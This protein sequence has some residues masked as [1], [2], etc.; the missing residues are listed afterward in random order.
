[1]TTRR[2]HLKT[3]V[4]GAG[5]GLFCRGAQPVPVRA[6]TRGPKF[7][8]FG[9]YDKLEFDPTNRYILANEIDF[10]NRAPAAGDVLRLGMIDT[11]ENDRWIALGD[12]HAFS[13]QQGCM[14]Q[15][16]P[17]SRSEVIWN[18]REGDRYVARIADALSRKPVRTI[19][20]PVHSINADA[21]VALHED[22][23][24]LEHLRPGYGYA[25][26]PDLYRSVAAPEETGLWRVDMNSG[27]ETLLLSHAQLAAIPFHKDVEPP[28]RT[29]KH[30][31]NHT[32]IAPDGKRFLVLHR[33]ELARPGAF[34]TR[35]FTADMNGSNLFELDPFGK[36]SHFIWRDGEYILAWAYQPSHGERFY[37]FKDRTREVSVIGPDVMT[38]NGHCTYL[39]G[40]KFILNDTYPD[41]RHLQHPFLYEIATGKRIPL[42]H[43]FEP[44]KYTGEFRC[45]LHP[46]YSRDG[47]KVIV[48]STHGGNGRQMYLIDISS[49]I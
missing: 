22:F 47:T 35:M 3:L 4:A 27:K 24:R 1:M 28:S 43:L 17:G 21:T 42:A 33:W 23:R 30:W 2:N 49:A 15:W 19:P 20:A 12:S 44:P 18:D 6:L 34:G 10:E 25:G 45:D 38:V 36:T 41:T 46:R 26:I 11:H 16:L 8:W 29:A 5:S 13:W 37:L 39:P 31:F 7:H 9:Y 32:M 14:L 48:D 40:G